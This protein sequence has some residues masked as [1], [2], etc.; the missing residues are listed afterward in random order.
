MYRWSW[1][2][3]PA[4]GQS[5]ADF[6]ARTDDLGHESAAVLCRVHAAKAGAL[7]LEF[8]HRDVLAAIRRTCG[9]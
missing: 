7:V 6:A 3:E 1:L 8:V 5:A 4:C 9:G 2:D